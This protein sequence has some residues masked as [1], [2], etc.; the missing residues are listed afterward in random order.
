MSGAAPAMASAQNVLSAFKNRFGLDCGAYDM[1]YNVPGGFPMDGPSAGITFAFAV[2]LMSAISGKAPVAGIA[3]TGEITVNGQV[4]P[5]SGVREKAAAGRHRGG[6]TS[7]N[8][9]RGQLR[10]AV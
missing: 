10:E 9:A 1:H 8:S 3:M 2:A 6:S 5:V 7:G 4:R